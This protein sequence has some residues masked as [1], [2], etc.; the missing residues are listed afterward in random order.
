M[1]DQYAVFGNPIE[2]SRSPM[3]HRE[4]ARQT[5]QPIDYRSESL[6]LAPTAFL[7]AAGWG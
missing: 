5:G 7:P 3:I 4:F 6:P 1:H 2:H